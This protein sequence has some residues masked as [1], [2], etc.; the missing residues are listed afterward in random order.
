MYKFHFILL[1]FIA[2]TD[3]CKDYDG[4]AIKQTGGTICCAKSCGSCGGSGCVS[5]PGG[6]NKCCT[7]NILT[8]GQICGL[9]GNKAPCTIPGTSENL[10]YFDLLKS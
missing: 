6:T 5:R 9:K 2:T 10:K 3:P 4:I 1:L 7:G 8:S